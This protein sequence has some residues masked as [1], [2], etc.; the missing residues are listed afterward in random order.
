MRL[1][2]GR[3]V[4]NDG[5]L[6]PRVFRLHLI[7]LARTSLF[8]GAMTF[9]SIFCSLLPFVSH[10]KMPF[11]L[12]TSGYGGDIYTLR[13]D[14]STSPGLEVTSTQPAGNAPTWL[15]LSK[16]GALLSSFLPLPWLPPTSVFADLL[17]PLL[18]P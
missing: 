9:K 11:Q 4:H 18:A 12:L 1:S 2:C 17:V 8:Q 3:P 15:T 14:L 13:L 6:S 5:P 10:C 16:D 7:R